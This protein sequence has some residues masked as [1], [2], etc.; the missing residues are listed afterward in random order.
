MA[1]VQWIV[2]PEARQ[3]RLP[4]GGPPRHADRRVGRRFAWA[5]ATSPE[6]RHD[7][8]GVLR[9][10]Q[11][12]IGPHTERLR[13][14][15]KPTIDHLEGCPAEDGADC[16]P[17]RS[18]AVWGVSGDEEA[19]RDPRRV[20]RARRRRSRRCP[21][22]G[23][24]PTRARRQRRRPL[25]RSGRR[26]LPGRAKRGEQLGGRLRRLAGELV[27][28]TASRLLM[29]VLA[30]DAGCGGVGSHGSVPSELGFLAL[31]VVGRQAIPPACDL[32]SRPELP[33]I[34]RPCARGLERRDEALP[35][36]PEAVQRRRELL[37]GRRCTSPATGRAEPGARRRPRSPPG[38][39]SAPSW[40]AIAPG[41]CSAR[42][43]SR[44]ARERRRRQGTSAPPVLAIPG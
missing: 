18:Y 26:G 32:L 15:G 13:M 37:S 24:R 10:D 41:P 3:P 19:D 40:A 39:S 20:F 16:K 1:Q 36:V 23:R 28:A 42:S 7:R 34:T 2:S 4:A 31:G 17:L 27:L 22:P 12:M 38:S 5:T 33:R 44:P 30:L 35:E 21:Q 9:L 6:L 8:V 25:P 14:V 11:R 29:L 43:T